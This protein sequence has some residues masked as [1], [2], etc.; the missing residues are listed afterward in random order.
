MALAQSASA[1][2]WAMASIG[3]IGGV[4]LLTSIHHAYGAIRYDTPWRMHAVYVSI[5]TFAVLIAALPKSRGRRGWR[6]ALYYVV[7]TTV[8]I[9][10][11]G[12]FEGGYNHVLKNALHLLGTSTARMLVLFPP[13]KYVLPEDVFFEASGVLQF[14]LAVVAA[15]ELARLWLHRRRE[16]G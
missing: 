16:S 7:A 10:L 15:R 14:P 4:L 5:A 2:R 8:P 6:A 12:F 11:I 3:W 13:P 1:D 9:G